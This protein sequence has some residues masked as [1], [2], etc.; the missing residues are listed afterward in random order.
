MSTL[1]G[2]RAAWDTCKVH[3]IFRDSSIPLNVQ[4]ADLFRQRIARGIW[5]VGHKIPSLDQ[6]GQEFNVARV[7]VRQAMT[8][9]AR[10][11]FVS[12]QQGRGTI[13]TGGPQTDRW[14]NVQ[15]TLEDLHKV[16]LDT[17]PEIR[18]L[19]ESAATPIVTQK[20]GVLAPKYRFIRRLHQR[21]GI[22]YCVISIYLDDRIFN[23]APNRFR[24]EIV[25]SVL[26]GMRIKVAR[27]RQTLT[28]STAD[29]EVGSLL[30][31]PVNSPIAEVRRVF[32]DPGGEIIYLAE[33][34][35]RGDFIR[36]EMDLR[37]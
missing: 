31:I 25:I 14:F 16:Y 2:F 1:A 8:R 23:R 11:G 7:T 34:T 37:V 36:L 4:L 3:P 22:P 32:T 15:T 12:P 29:L 10:E 35:Y 17:K 30:Q 28:I 6:L 18:N 20:D 13:V 33:V 21:G 19:S 9:L 27:A 26:R 24:R 5:P